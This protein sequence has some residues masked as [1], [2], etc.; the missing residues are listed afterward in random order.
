MATSGPVIR[1]EK[2]APNWC[3]GRF[4]DYLEDSIGYFLD[5]SPEFKLEEVPK[6]EGGKSGDHMTLYCT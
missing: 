1:L 5:E 3:R 6:Q 4:A 2:P